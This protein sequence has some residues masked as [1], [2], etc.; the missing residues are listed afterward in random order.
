MLTKL[1]RLE[2][3]KLFKSTLM[4]SNYLFIKRTIAS[5][6]KNNSK[7]KQMILNTKFLLNRFSM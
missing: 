5:F 3:S 2:L 4:T 6:L 7:G 1:L